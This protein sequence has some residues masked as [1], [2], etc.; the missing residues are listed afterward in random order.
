MRPANSS[1][2]TALLA[3]W[4]L[5]GASTAALAAPTP[6]TFFILDGSGSMWGKAGGETK[7][8]AAKAVMAEVVPSL[9]PDVKVGLIAYGHR[10]KG[11]C[12]DIEVLVPAGSDDRQSLLSRVQSI[13]PKGKTPISDSVAT[14]VGLLRTKEAETTIVLVSDGIETCAADPCAVAE[15]LKET[16]IQF[17][18]HVV[19]FGVDAAAESQLRCMAEKT[20]GRYF[21]A[22]DAG[23]LRTALG[24]VKQEVEQKVEKARSQP[25]AAGT[26]LPKIVVRMPPGAAKTV[27]GLRILK[28]DGSP[29][30]ETKG[31]K[32]ETVHP[33]PP[34]TYDVSYT[35][36]QPNYGKPTEAPIGRL[37][38]TMGQT[39][40]LV[41]GSIVFN[42]AERFAKR[43]ALIKRLVVAD[44]GSGEPLAIVHSRNNGYYTFKPKPAPAGVYDIL[45]YYGNSPAPVRVARDVAVLPG[46]ET[47]ITL[48]SGIVFK[49]VKS[50]PISGW[51]LVPLETA[52]PD[53]AG[54]GP[55]AAEPVLQAR[56]GHGNRKALWIPYLVPPGRYQLLAHV[57]GMSEP[58]PVAPELEIKR[59]EVLNFDSGL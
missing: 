45:L 29:L 50:T 2:W 49:A 40:E 34:G 1:I 28:T 31:T 18:L 9:D 14:A 4:T 3:V 59:G 5:L 15:K 42:V 24:S 48:D 36:K 17:V 26:G 11:D 32:A 12:S 8:E 16:G 56:P 22:D 33:V 38:L 58:L 44:A 21:G 57:E 46:K 51:D 27:A 30:K 54:S 6:E 53:E 43:A 41:L 20:G 55:A 23:S 52:L 37:E 47:M 7:I 13:Q 19:G 25:R 35:L 10:R 39:R